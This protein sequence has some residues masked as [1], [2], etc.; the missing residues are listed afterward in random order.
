M[1]LG[2][3]MLHDE[4]LWSSRAGSR[5]RLRQW[6][7]LNVGKQSSQACSKHQPGTVSRATSKL[8]TVAGFRLLLAVITLIA[9]SFIANRKRLPR[10][11]YRG[12]EGPLRYWRKP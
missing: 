5:P 11:Q 6:P 2:L 7:S 1:F 8:Y 12:E 3:R 9:L 4:G 10:R